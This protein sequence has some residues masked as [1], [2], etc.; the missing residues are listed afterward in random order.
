GADI[1]RHPVFHQVHGDLRELQGCSPLKKQ[2]LVIF[3]HSEKLSQ[4]RLSLLDDVGRHFGA[5]AHFHD[6]PSASPVN[7]HLRLGVLSNLL[8]QHCR[9]GR[10]IIYSAHFSFFLLFPLQKS[11]FSAPSS[12]SRHDFIIQP[13]SVFRQAFFSSRSVSSKTSLLAPPAA[14]M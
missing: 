12:L 2:N 11:H 14:T 13:E 7:H 9:T 1:V 5:G 6:G 8:R 4:V 10:V 3:R